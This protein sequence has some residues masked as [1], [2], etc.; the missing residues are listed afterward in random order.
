[1]SDGLTIFLACGGTC[2]FNLIITLLFNTLTKGAKQRLKDS[3]LLKKGLQALLRSN[4]YTIH[5]KCKKKGYATLAEKNDFENLYQSYHSLGK[6]GVM[7]GIREAF[8]ELP[9]EQSEK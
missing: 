2:L 1:M 4:L 5:E 8:L 6:N 9:L 3:E 7:D